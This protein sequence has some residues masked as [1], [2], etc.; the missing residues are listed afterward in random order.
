MIDEV[1]KISGKADP[2]IISQI[3]RNIHN[4]AVGIM[5]A[6]ATPTDIPDGKFVIV[7]DGSAV[8]VLYIKTGAGRLAYVALTV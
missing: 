1:I 4:N 7:D 2:T 3:F 5:Y 8:P 6:T